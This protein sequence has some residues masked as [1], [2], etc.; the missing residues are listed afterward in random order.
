MKKKKII[1]GFCGLEILINDYSLPH[2]ILCIWFQQMHNLIFHYLWSSVYCKYF[3]MEL[4]KRLYRLMCCPST[5]PFLKSNETKALMS[6]KKNEKTIDL[7]YLKQKASIKFQNTFTCRYFQILHIFLN[8][9]P[10]HCVE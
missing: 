8:Y 6:L 10:I 4:K 5:S 3:L 2:H 1:F 9:N 7:H